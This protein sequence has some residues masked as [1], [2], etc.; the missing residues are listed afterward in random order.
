LIKSILVPLELLLFLEEHVLH[1]L[2]EANPDFGVG[3]GSEAGY[4]GEHRVGILELVVAGSSKG[5]LH[6]IQVEL[7]SSGLRCDAPRRCY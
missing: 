5:R 7:A 1:L 2:G 4:L 3:A 6:V